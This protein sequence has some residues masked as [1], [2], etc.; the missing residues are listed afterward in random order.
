MGIKHGR[1]YRDIIQDFS[2][3]IITIH[4]CNELFEMED[5]DWAEM[6][7]EQKMEL[8]QTLADDIFY[9]LAA[10]PQI[11]IGDSVIQHDPV[12]HVIKVVNNEQVIHLVRLV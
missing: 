5:A 6:N 7:A 4:G 2:R 8:V 3:A 1:E 11:E 12:N 9:A 10:D